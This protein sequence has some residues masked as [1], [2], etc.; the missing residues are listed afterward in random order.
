MKPIITILLLLVF[1]FKQPVSAQTELN[2]EHVA[3]VHNLIDGYNEQNFIKMNAQ[4]SGLMKLIFSKENISMI[5]AYQYQMMGKA[6]IVYI[7]NTGSTYRIGLKYE[8]DTTEIDQLGIS[9]SKKLKI[10]GLSSTQP[11]LL[12]SNVTAPILTEAQVIAAI[13]SIVAHKQQYG[14]YS[15]CV[16]IIQHDQEIYN[17]CGGYISVEN[18]L[19]LTDTTLFDLASVSKQFTAM[20]VMLAVQKGKLRYDNTIQDFYPDFPYK[21]ITIENLLTHTSGLPD[22]MALF[23]EHWD[24]TKIAINADVIQLLTSYKPKASF[25]PNKQYEYS[26]TGYAILASI[27]EKVEGD[28]Y[29]NILEK[30]I[31]RPLGMERSFAINPNNMNRLM[32]ADIAQGHEY[33]TDQK[34]FALARNLP[35]NSM[36]IY[37]GGIVGDGGVYCSAAD[38]S[39]WDNAIRNYTLLDKAAFAPA[40]TPYQ[41]RKELSQYGYGWELTNETGYEQLISHSGNWAG[42]T[43]LIV[44]FV[45][46]QISIIGLSNNEY[47]NIQ[48]LAVQIGKLLNQNYK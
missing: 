14:N 48:P 2:P 5:Y 37:L 22:Y 3:V 4:F 34:S 39:L 28:T 31:F 8:R 18:K 20:A 45:D 6:D 26:N 33:Q 11:K 10:N 43:H 9:I 16:M 25:K 46:K 13:D 47:F 44:H 27:L 38:L 19:P 36:Y 32:A 42:S 21:H 17:S 12:F 41:T 29:A 23:E 35:K 15:G 7:K 40:T 1:A 24:T 30:E